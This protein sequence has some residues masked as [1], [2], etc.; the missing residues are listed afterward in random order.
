MD[1]SLQN[2]AAGSTEFGDEID[3]G[4][5]LR[6]FK[7]DRAVLLGVDGITSDL[8]F[9]P[10]VIE[11]FED[12]DFGDMG[13]DANDLG[14]KED[15]SGSGGGGFDIDAFDALDQSTWPAGVDTPDEMITWIGNNVLANDPTSWPSGI[16][17]EAA[18]ATWLI[19]NVTLLDSL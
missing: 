2:I 13:G 16:D 12:F 6:P 1:R 11:D 3:P 18:L 15:G 7:V 9:Q 8:D 17:S 19:Q 4:T 10:P 14:D 5:I